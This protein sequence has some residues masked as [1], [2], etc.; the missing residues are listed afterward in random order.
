M[1]AGQRKPRIV[2]VGGGFAGAYTALYLRKQL[3]DS[4]DIELINRDNY[5]VFQPLL[6]EVASGTISA[7]DAVVPLR[8]M[9]KGIKVRQ[10]EVVALDTEQ[11]RLSFLQGSHRTLID[12]SYD[13]LVLTTGVD[14]NL[15][16]VPGMAAHAMTIK[17][18]SDAYQIRNHIIQCLE[19][20][21]VTINPETKQRLLTFVV[22]GGGFSGVETV[23]EIVEMIH[24]ALRYYPN[25]S[26]DE[27]K[28]I[29]IQRSGGLLPEL[30]PKLGEYTVSQFE[31]RGI[32]VL[33]NES[34]ASITGSEVVL[35]GGQRIA[36]ATLISSIGNK[37]PAFVESL[38]V[39]LRRGKIPVEPTLQVGDIDGLWALG[40]IASVPLGSPTRDG[41]YDSYAPPTAQFAVQE[42][43][44]CA[45]NI[46]AA[47]TGKPL[48]QFAY[49]PR[50]SLASLGSYSGVGEV[51][52]IRLSGIIGWAVWRGFYILRIPGLTTKIRITLNW[53]YDYFLPRNIVHLQQ[54]NRPSLTRQH[55]SAGDTIF[56]KGQLL[57]AFY[58][59]ES[60]V[61]QLR[62]ETT[63]FSREFAEGE[64]FG[65][66]LIEHN[67]PLTGDFTALQ[68]TVI[69]RFKRDEFA[70]LRDAMPC[71]QDYFA[72]ME[73]S[74]YSPEMRH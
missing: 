56:Y 1:T 42:A 62:D 14:A 33:L 50:G 23:G 16:L 70:T 24:R 37:T 69:I 35:T 13:H 20:A 27:I 61:C 52:G 71:L 48:S 63:G 74:K 46:A 45:R 53:L 28:P 4:V 7:Q 29:I 72:D 8:A 65:E 12:L 9:V 51:F 41:E 39:S 22:A 5:F 43:L 21:D 40:D 26:K 31:R 15:D 66:R 25:V 68:D 38:P 34:V 10:A 64:H 59:I 54:K 67:H 6:P 44:H 32:A 11:K 57:D 47:I 3:R 19:W 73:E 30:H 18:L 55:Y 49:K 36:A 60:G 58:I 17:D 2:I